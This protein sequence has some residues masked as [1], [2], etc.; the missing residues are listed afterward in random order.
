MYRS[1]KAALL[2]LAVVT[3]ATPAFAHTGHDVSFAM[4][5]GLLHPLYGLDHMLA[6]FAVGLLAWQMGGHA[7]WALPV[8]FVAVM[9]I[10]ATAATS[11]LA[12]SGAE[13]A[14]L[15]SVVVLGLAI[16]TRARAP[17]TLAAAITGAFA[18]MH[19][20]AHGAEIPEVA[21]FVGYALGF[22]AATAVLH[23]TG[24]GLGWLL[25]RNSAA[26]RV[27]GAL[28]AFAGLGLAS[29]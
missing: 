8:T 18:F 20:Y 22:T 5:D 23:A 29:V 6:M 1:T 21:G 27:L 7:R 19:G 25:A 12:V 14:I 11:G 4:R 17:L 16:A 24:L 26:V 28:I 9:A 2:S 15:A 13:V 10:G 3:L